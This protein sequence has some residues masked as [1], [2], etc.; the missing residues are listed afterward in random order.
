MSVEVAATISQPR[1][2]ASL[3]S[4]YILRMLGLFIVLPVLSLSGEDY[5]GSSLFLLGVALGIYGITQALLQ[6]PMGMLSDRYGRKPLIFIGLLLFAAGS[7]VAANADSVWGLILGRALQGA[8]AIA[9]VVIA[10]VGDLTTAEHRTKAMASMGVSIGIAFALALVIGPIISSVSVL[11]VSGIRLLFWVTVGLSLCG[12]FILFVCVPNVDLVQKKITDLSLHNLKLVLANRQYVLLYVGV[13]ILHF[14]LMVF[15]LAVPVLLQAHD[16]DA[17]QHAWVYLGLMLASFMIV[18]PVMIV[19]ERFKKVKSA[20]QL[21]I[22][23]FMLSL[24]ALTVMPATFAGLLACLVVFFAAFN[25]LEASLPSL[26][27]KVLPDENKGAG[28]GV[29]ASCQFAGASLGG[30]IGGAC[31]AVWGF[32]LTF[33]VTALLVL[34]WCVLVRG[35]V[36][37]ERVY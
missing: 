25:Y 7:L 15:F 11:G 18:V 28:S 16:L 14:A 29:F 4:L 20:L 36:I 37:P 3:A 33:L 26:L 10:M 1:A 30:I 34:V 22:V 27:T 23:S 32:A 6:I 17:K 5:G 21:A 35:M 9:G 8:G 12:I 13:F 2:I 24:L 31:Y 19:A